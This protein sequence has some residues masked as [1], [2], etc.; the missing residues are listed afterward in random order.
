MVLAN[1]FN[2]HAA[3]SDLVSWLIKALA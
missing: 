1:Q 3:H 2:T